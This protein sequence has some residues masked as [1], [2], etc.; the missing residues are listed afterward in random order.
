MTDETEEI[1]CVNC[2]N[3]AEPYELCCYSLGDEDYFC[4]GRKYKPKD[5]ESNE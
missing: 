5:K 2:I 1:K 3:F 4:C